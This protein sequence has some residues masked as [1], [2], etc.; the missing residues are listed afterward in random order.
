VYFSKPLSSYEAIERH[1]DA[2]GRVVEGPDIP[3][4]IIDAEPTDH[5]TFTILV[6]CLWDHYLP[7][8][9]TTKDLLEATLRA[10]VTARSVGQPVTADL[11]FAIKETAKHVLR[12]AL[13]E[14][15]LVQ[16][17]RETKRGE[18]WR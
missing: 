13:K 8:D 5:N 7:V 18:T 14:R 3:T 15:H 11:I 1:L 17:H 16:K 6:E 2:V 10:A 12:R 9:D 4:L